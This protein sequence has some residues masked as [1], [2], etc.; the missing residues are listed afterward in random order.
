MSGSCQYTN[1]VMKLRMGTN[2][3]NTCTKYEGL[4]N[5]EG[6]TETRENTNCLRNNEVKKQKNSLRSFAASSYVRPRRQLRCFAALRT[7]YTYSQFFRSPER[8]R[9]TKSHLITESKRLALEA[10][11]SAVTCRLRAWCGSPGRNPWRVP[12]SRY[13][14]GAPPCRWRRRRS[15]VMS[16]PRRHPAPSAR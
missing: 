7:S 1:D 3:A 10:S 13:L 4:R 5:N 11:L 2:S 12:P 8:H 15:L 14:P 6:L 16:R 9:H